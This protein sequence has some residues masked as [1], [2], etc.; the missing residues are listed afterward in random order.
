MSS[1]LNE[2]HVG[3]T[4]SRQVGDVWVPNF[5]NLLNIIKIDGLE[6]N[7]NNKLFFHHGDCLGADTLA[8][9]I[10]SALNWNIIIH[11]PI[12]SKFRAYCGALGTG[13][14]DIRKRQDY[15]KRNR[16]I[17]D[18]CSILLAAPLT[19]EDKYKRSGTWYTIRYARRFVSEGK[20]IT[21]FDTYDYNADSIDKI[22]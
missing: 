18:S 14:F 1:T 2:V 6:N 19:P 10:V 5:K 8:H 9:S 11:P 20:R 21:I 7:P 15:L 17:V 12:N 16:D 3:F 22:K 4:G 13:T